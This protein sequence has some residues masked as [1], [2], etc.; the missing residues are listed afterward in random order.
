MAIV[1]NALFY[2]YKEKILSLSLPV[3]EEDLLDDR[4]LLE[5]DLEKQLEIY[6]TPFDYLNENAKVVI[7]GITPGLHQMKKAYSAVLECRNSGL[8]NEE[9]LHEVKRKA[10]FEGS[11]RKNLVKML[12][13]LGLHAPLG[14]Y[15]TSE[16][17]GTASHLVYNTSLLPHAV[18]F[19]GRNF[20]GSRPDI[21]KT[22]FLRKYALD[23]FA[24]DI[25]RLD[26]P[27][28]IPLGGNVSRVMQYLVD[29]HS[30]DGSR[31]IRGFQHPS[32]GNGHRHRRFRE[33]KEPMANQIDKY[34]IT[35][36]LS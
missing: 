23:N 35:V 4:F 30:L 21:L 5:R 26:S 33:N 12:D 22:D 13:E 2:K 7:V 1:T 29:H 10:S 24:R 25:A 19:R 15:S 36:A 32:G 6:Y 11:M 9:L 3:A 31:I 8:N 34:F 27:L 18:F 14:I 28:I 20:N 16:L 17:F